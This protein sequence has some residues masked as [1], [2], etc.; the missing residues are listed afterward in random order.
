MK[1]IRIRDGKNWIR[2]PDGKNSD[3]GS[4]MDKIRIRDPGWKK[5]GSGIRNKHIPEPQHWLTVNEGMGQ[6]IASSEP[7]SRLE[8]ARKE[9]DMGE[10]VDRTATDSGKAAKIALLSRIFSKPPS[11]KYLIA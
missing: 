2:D 11:G 6:L 1:K 9:T 3:P 5:F 10:T 7:S 4:G 8:S